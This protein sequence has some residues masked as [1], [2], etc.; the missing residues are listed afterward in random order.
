MPSNIDGNGV[1]EPPT[2]RLA[3]TAATGVTHES[4]E[5][6]SAHHLRGACSNALVAHPAGILQGI[7]HQWT[8]RVE[9]V[10]ISFLRSLLENDIIP[11]IPPLGCDG[12]GNS[13]RLNSDAVAVEVA[14]SLG[15]VKLIYLTN[16]AGVLLRRPD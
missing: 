4:L 1:T 2:L 10:D 9:R 6:L 15:A 16:S 13:Y 7:D 8:G 14:K 11:V 5:G 3:L 12:E